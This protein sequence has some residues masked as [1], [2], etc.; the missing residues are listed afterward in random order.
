MSARIE[1]QAPVRHSL[2]AYL[3][4][5]GV[6]LVVLTA[7]LI[8][9]MRGGTST[10]TKTGT[11]TPVTKTVEQTQTGLVSTGGETHPRPFEGIVAPGAAG[12]GGG[13]ADPGGAATSPQQI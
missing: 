6:V 11:T 8:W 9:N 2:R 3:W 7:M 4:V 12:G 1:V 5:L 13:P 10:A